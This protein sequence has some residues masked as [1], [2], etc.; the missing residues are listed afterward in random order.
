MTVDAGAH[1]QPASRAAG[2]LGVAG[3]GPPRRL[4]GGLRR[5]RRRRRR[6]PGTGGGPAG[7]RQRRQRRPRRRAPRSASD[8]GANS[9]D[10]Y[11]WAE[12]DDPG[13]ASTS[14]GNIEITSS[15]PTRSDRQA[16]AAGGTG[17]TTWS[18][19]TGAYIPQ[20]V[21]LGPAREARP[22]PHPQFQN[23]DSLPGQA[24]DPGNKYSICKDW[25][26]T[27]WIY[28]NTVVT[29]RRS[30][31]WADFIAAAQGEASGNMSVLDTPA[32][33]TGIYFWANGIDWNTEDP[34]E[35]DAC[36]DVH[37]RR[38]RPA[39]QGVRLVPRHQPRRGQLRPVAG[40]ERRRPPGP[41]HRVGDDP[42]TYTWGL[43]APVTELWMDNW[44]ILKGARTSTP[45]TT[46]STSS[47]TRPT[48]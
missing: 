35:L 24:W 45:P 26:S 43:G 20:M 27:G 17:A 12:Y 44:C 37:R 42:R 6:T 14:F 2:F 5:R 18:C 38:V 22:E 25:G 19:P 36:E 9:F 1:L 13:S 10:L 34:A 15:T 48:R 47:W 7:E 41:P 4:P 31:T 21:G 32:N 28:D 8:S 11:T 29:E 46:S 39:H 33:V 40:L 23:L 16:A 30:T 3:L